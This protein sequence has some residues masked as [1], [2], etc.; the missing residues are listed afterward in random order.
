MSKMNFN[1]KY[2]HYVTLRLGI[3]MIMIDSPNHICSNLTGI[4]SMWILI[5]S[6]DPAVVSCVK[7]DMS[8]LVA[9]G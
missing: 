5:L 4:H 9:V 1:E 2:L 6:H 3:I 7:G 8:I